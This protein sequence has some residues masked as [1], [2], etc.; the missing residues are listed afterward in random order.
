M[1]AGRGYAQCAA[2]DAKG[3]PVGSEPEHE[4]RE[5]LM[6]R[7]VQSPEMRR[8]VELV[9]YGE[10]TFKIADATVTDAAIKETV[11]FRRS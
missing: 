9:R 2:S 8:L 10:V 7:I 1:H 5:T 3:N 6:Q 4:E 11:R